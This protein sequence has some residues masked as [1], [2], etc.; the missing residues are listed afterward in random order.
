V[1][2]KDIPKTA[3][4]THEGHYE[5]LVMPFGLTN[6]PSTFQSLMNH[7]FN[8][9]LRKFILVFFDDILVYSKD[10]KS[11]ME[12]L[13]VTLGLLR[14]N[15]LYA[16]M[17]KCRFGVAEVDYLGHIVSAE[18][19]CVDPGKI[20]AMVDWPLPSNIKS[21]RGFLGLM[22]YYR[23]FIRGY[24]S[25]ATPLTAMLK[26]NSYS[27]SDSAR[28]AFNVLKTA[29]TQA[30][31]L[32]LPNFSKQFTIECDASGLGVGAVLMQDKRPIAYLSKALKGKA[33]HMS[34]YEKEL[35]A[36]VTAIQKWRPYLF[37]HS[38]VVKTD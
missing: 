6:T 10:L 18:G 7:I 1:V 8:P 13:Q 34:T 14:Q 38:F 28:A 4:R 37:G 24:G 29:V 33:L 3:F 32:A 30:P 25:I 12:H 15:Q 26:K 23:K 31:V 35:F 17:S 22:G 21:L 5:F 16:K 11:H 20:K 2:E 19:V 27:W 9:Y 36:L